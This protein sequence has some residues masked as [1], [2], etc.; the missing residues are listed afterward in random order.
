MLNDL[1]KEG[2]EV[3]L[4]GNEAIARGAIEAGV[5][6]VSAYPGTPSSEIAD[7]LAKACPLLKGKMEYY[8]EYSTNEKVAFETA[9]GASLAGKRAM[10]TMKHVGLN[11]ASDSLFSFAYVG[12]R[13]GF[14]VVSADD[15]SMHS[16]QNE[17]DNRWYGKS[18]NL[19]VIEPSSVNEAKELAKLSFEIS[20]K[21]G[22]P[23]IFRTYTRLSHSSGIVRLGRI[24]K[25]RINKI[26]WTRRPETDV[27]LPAHAR[28]LKPILQEKMRRI[29]DYFSRFEYNWIEGGECD[30]GIVACGLSYRYVKDALENLKASR[31]FEVPS[32]LKLSSMYPL[33]KKLIEKFSAGLKKIV[34]VEEVD[35]FMELH[36]RAMLDTPITGKIN[37]YFP[38][39]YEYNVSVV[40]ESLAKVFSIEP[41]KDYSKFLEKAKKISSR[42]PPRPPVLC[43]GCPHTST[44]YAIKKAGGEVFPSDIGC[45]T[46]GINKPLEAVDTTICMGASAG[47]SN[48][49]SYFVDGKIV[50]TIGD[51]T[52]FHSGMAPLINAV[53]NNRD[54]TL[55]IIDNSTTAMTGHQPHPGTG[56]TVAGGGKKISIEDVVRGMGVEFVEIVNS[57]NVKKL[58]ETIKNAIKHR[59]VSV[60]ISRHPCAILWTRER[61][62][63]GVAPTRFYVTDDCNGCLECMNSFTCPAISLNEGVEIDSEL[64]V[65]CAV[66]SA[67]CPQKAIKPIRKEVKS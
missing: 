64:C 7:S 4:L 21:F 28:R 5:D 8:M 38:M 65:G 39:N 41:S 60:V 49:L 24:P 31:G 40:E 62:K 18:A 30:V 37:G 46:L 58:I 1:V 48:G 34:V 12:A 32:I 50:A 59:G 56:K 19:P 22:L 2:G 42:A 54:Y 15:P 29:E 33:P 27:I 61:R 47:V 66:C 10:C 55:V 6:L 35:P 3:F 11:V 13:G 57:Y 25:K 67:I 45:Y 9:I 51:S 63:R 23:I 16:S 43:P 14:V 20:E 44:F 53:Y 26:K 17:Q 52:F 36:L